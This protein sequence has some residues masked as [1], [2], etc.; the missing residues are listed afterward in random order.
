MKA[1]TRIGFRVLG[2][3]AKYNAEAI[4]TA[5]GIEYNMK[6]RSGVDMLITCPI[7]AL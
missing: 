6:G 5:V 2:L 1:R 3:A 4:E 7:P